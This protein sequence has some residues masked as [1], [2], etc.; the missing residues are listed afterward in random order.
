M[1]EVIKNNKTFRN[2][3]ISLML[4][5]LCLGMLC[6]CVKEKPDLSG[7]SDIPG[8][9]LEGMK[10]F[11]NDVVTGCAPE[12]DTCVWDEI[13]EGHLSIMKAVLSYAEIT[14]MG[15]P[16]FYEESGSVDL[17]ITLSYI[18]LDDIIETMYTSY[19]TVDQIRDLLEEYD[20]IN[21][22][23]LTLDFERDEEGCW[24]LTKSSAKKI[25]K[26]FSFDRIARLVVVDYS[27]E[28][29]RDI[30]MAY[31]KNIADCKDAENFPAD[32]DLE[33]YRYYDDS[34]QG[35]EGSLTEDA[36]ARF[37]A[38]YMEY[39]LSHYPDVKREWDY[40]FYL[41]GSAPSCADLKRALTTD[42]Y[43]IQNFANLLRYLYLDMDIEELVDT[44]TALIYD[45]LAE[46][47]PQCDS[48]QYSL[49]AMVSPYEN[50]DEICTL[51]GYVINEP[52]S[53]DYITE[54]E[55]GDMDYYLEKAID[56]LHDN[57]EADD[58]LYELMLEKGLSIEEKIKT[59]V[60]VSA[61]GHPNQ[62][63]GTYDYV[64]SWCEDG[65]IIY[66]RSDTDEQGFSMSYTREDT[67]LHTAGYC[68]DEEGIW[69]ASYYDRIFFPGNE[70]LVD[71]WLD[72]EL[73]VDAQVIIV[74]DFTNEIEVFLP[75]DELP[76]EGYYEL[77]LWETDH[78]HV[79]SYVTITR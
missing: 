72:G 47:I 9:F 38:A 69:I 63:V 71:W 27:N 10:N 31:L 78:H 74:G 23:T 53:V 61:S 32:L 48:E 43:E 4:T 58:E 5:V 73:I 3:I 22:K 15:D 35:G 21:E 70:I 42:E 75:L 26:L 60:S 29:A 68:I 14:E 2:V 24:S 49:Y 50:A 39:V 62:A 65:S 37:V 12:F 18:A 55:D 76:E 40:S 7:I 6:S 46:A 17:Q 66:G 77:R 19:V 45:T 8:T 64:P 56:L 36:V 16:V 11:D 28:D 54:Y 1:K 44:Q 34:L 59:D 30:F 51:Q 33:S 41:T 52:V 20:D 25:Y 13:D 67:W 57:G 79:I